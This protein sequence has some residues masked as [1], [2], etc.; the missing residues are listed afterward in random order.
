[1]AE[2]KQTPEINEEL[3]SDDTAMLRAVLRSN[4]ARNIMPVAVYHQ[5]DY[6]A[7]E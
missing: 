4:Y 2:E 7:E 5:A 3:G 6:D 1:M